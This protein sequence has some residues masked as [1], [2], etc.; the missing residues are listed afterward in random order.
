MKSSLAGFGGLFFLPQIDMKK[1][2]RVVE[3]KGKERKFV[4]RTLGKT[5]LKLPV[6]NMGVML[7]DNPNIIRA[8][9]DSGVL[10][11]DTAHGYM[12]G[13]NEE[14]IGEVIKRR[15]R[16]SYY[17]A[18]KVNLPQD[19]TKGLFTEGATTEEFLRRLD[20]S[21]KRLGLDYVDILHLHGVSRKESVVFEPALKAFEQAKRD[22]KIRFSGVSTHSN[23]P[24]VIDAVTDLKV[25]DVILTS[26]TFKQKHYQEV[27]KAIA[28]ASQ[29]GVGIIGM[30]A[31]RG[32]SQQPPTVKNIPASFKWILQDPN[33]HTIVTGFTTFEHIEMDLS[34]MEDLTLTEHEKIELQKEAVLPG[35]YCQGCRQCLGQCPEH[36]P[37]PDLMR[38]YMYTYAYRNLTHAQ[39]LVLSLN[40]SNRIC[41]DCTACPVKCLNGWDVGSKIRDIARLREVPT[42]FIA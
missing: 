16:D 26:Y 23:E 37:I 19:R 21:L 11:L 2:L 17:I 24:E 36:L 4:Y 29:A 38:A 15:P 8:A 7:T 5:G 40:L 31:V 10:L 6:I 13:R 25:H 1:E 30:K 27:R 32:I 3:A 20:T 12:Q 39:D 34:V 35:L 14:T 18:T 9:L 42:E 41:E 33:V 28:R 22:G